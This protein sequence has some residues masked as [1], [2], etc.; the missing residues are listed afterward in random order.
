MGGGGDLSAIQYSIITQNPLEGAT[1]F[2]TG[3]HL[4]HIKEHCSEP[5]TYRN[6]VT[7]DSQFVSAL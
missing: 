6:D 4:N 5:H 3:S 7:S 1:P 2:K